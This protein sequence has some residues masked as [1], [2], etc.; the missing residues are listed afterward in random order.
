[1]RI[2]GILLIVAGLFYAVAKPL[3]D[4]GPAG[5]EV[6]KT[7]FY[8]RSNSSDEAKGW[9]VSK[10]FLET[11]NNPQNIRITVSR[12]TGKLDEG[13]NL[14]LLVRVAPISQSGATL[15]SV[16][17]QPVTIDLEDENSN[18]R[19]P[20]GQ[21]KIL[22][23]TKEFEIEQTG[24]FKIGAFPIA[25]DNVTVGKPELEIDRKIIR[26][27]AVLIGRAEAGDSSNS[28]LGVGLVVLG[29]IVLSLFRRRKIQ[30]NGQISADQIQPENEMEEESLEN[31]IDRSGPPVVSDEP[32]PKRQS[33]R[34]K[35]E[36]DV[37]KSIQW[38]RDA[39]KD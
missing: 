5:E 30:S 29:I 7:L 14:K 24:Q 20:S 21:M 22:V 2:L 28:L 17:N 38:G 19:S 10:V 16:L 11:G 32:E 37:G 33:A 4:S 6:A 25:A 15:P 1:M 3:F 36:T 23:S 27:E 9:Q 26:I 12:M 18:T 35:R 8:D 34:P 39:D 31:P 13:R